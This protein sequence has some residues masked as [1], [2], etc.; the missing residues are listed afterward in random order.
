MDLRIGIKQNPQAIE[1][2]LPEEADATA[3]KKEVEQ[4]V[5]ASELLWVADKDGNETAISGEQ[6]AFIEI[7][8]ADKDRKIGF[9]A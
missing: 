3:L 1:L 7:R 9:G 5:S 2:A 4:A 6:I 8:S